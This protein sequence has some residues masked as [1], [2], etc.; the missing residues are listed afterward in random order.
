MVEKNEIEEHF[1]TMLSADK[2]VILQSKLPQKHPFT[3]YHERLTKVR[4]NYLQQAR[5]KLLLLLREL[6]KSGSR[7]SEAQVRDSNARGR[8]LYKGVLF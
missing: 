1:S 2:L 8:K 6:L 5:R 7:Q 3:C 4:L